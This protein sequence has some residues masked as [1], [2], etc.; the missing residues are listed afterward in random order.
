MGQG[1]L[2]ASQLVISLNQAVHVHELVVLLGIQSWK[3][4]FAALALPPVPWIVL[5]LLG[6]RLMFWR[7]GVG[8][9][10]ILISSAGMW[11]SCCTAV[12]L[13]LERLLLKPPPVLTQ[14]QIGAIKRDVAAGRKTV[15]VILGGGRNAMSPEYGLSTLT[16]TSMLR[17][18]YAIWLARQTGAPMLFSG[19]VGH[20]GTVG[21]SEA[22]TAARVAEH[23]YGRPIKWLESES[24][25]TKE[26]ATRSVALLKQHGLSDVVLVTHGN[27][28]KR[29]L[30]AMQ[31][32]AERASFQLNLTPAP[33]GIAT[34]HDRPVLAWTPSR[35]GFADVHTVLH[36][37]LGFLLGA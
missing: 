37:A 35:A 21:V 9:L 23:D 31:L 7:R 34:P 10:L 5:T 32:E 16:A 14:D 8:W 29:S 20:E 18:H 11:L 15:I 28:M 30:R 25:D 17:L 22:E 26:N 12:G 27:H 24:R 3:P 36:E 33:V 1:N 19:G 13:W 4:V 6:A 2:G